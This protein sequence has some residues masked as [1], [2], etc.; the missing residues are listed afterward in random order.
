MRLSE[1]GK[2][3]LV[4]DEGKR[5]EAYRDSEGIPTIG[6]GF[7]HIHGRPVNMSDKL[8]VEQITKMLPQILKEYEDAVN[9]AITMPMFQHEFDA[10]VC[11]CFNIGANA[12]KLSGV[13]KAFNSG[14]KVLAAVRMFQWLKPIVLK[15]RRLRDATLFA[16]GEYAT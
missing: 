5:T 16:C 3:H 10:F 2:R 13:V 7:T 1:K 12:F 4:V 9:E 6:I 11:F 8:T 14:N 15:D